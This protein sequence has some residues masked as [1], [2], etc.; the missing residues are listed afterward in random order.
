MLKQFTAL[1][2]AILCL[3]GMQDDPPPPLEDRQPET[4]PERS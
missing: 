4:D 3:T 1:F 2:L